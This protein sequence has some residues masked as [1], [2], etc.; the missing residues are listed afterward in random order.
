RSG[1]TMVTARLLG[2]ERAEAARFSF[3]LSIP[4]S[5]A[6]GALKTF[7]MIKAGDTAMLHDA[8]VVAVLSALTGIVA[9][10][11]LMVYLRRATFALFAIYR[12]L[13]GAALLYLVYIA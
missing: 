1:I 12:V 9:I 3:L 7:E 6:A 4:A 11:F 2:F 10:A 13:L 5:A 8:V